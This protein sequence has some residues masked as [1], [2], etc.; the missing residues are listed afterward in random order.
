MGATRLEA[1]APGGGGGGGGG[2]GAAAAAGATL[3]EEGPPA[4]GSGGSGALGSHLAHHAHL[5]LDLP[6]DMLEPG[7]EL[8][9][10]EVDTLPADW[11]GLHPL[12]PLHTPHTRLCTPAH[13]RIHPHLPLT[14]P[15]TLC[16]LS[17]PHA[18]LHPLGM[19]SSQVWRLSCRN[20]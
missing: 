7:L 18:A 13:T 11:C 19:T 8:A 10:A 1:R 16:T 14:S 12:A 4:G 2:G 5:L 6:P 9:E 17:T 15:T 20:P 3:A